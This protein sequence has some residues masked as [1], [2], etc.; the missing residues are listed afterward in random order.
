MIGVLAHHLGQ[1][2]A[3]EAIT[4]VPQA[5]ASR[6]G[7]RTPRRGRED[8]G[9][10]AAVEGH[11]VRS[12]TPSSMRTASCTP[13]PA[14]PR[15]RARRATPAPDV[16]EQQVAPFLAQEAQGVEDEGEVLAGLDGAHVMR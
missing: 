3:A 11:E 5:M 15:R 12:S 6:Q 2:A 14:G 16:H 13:P 10:G 9:H 1:G 8:E 4:G 7:C